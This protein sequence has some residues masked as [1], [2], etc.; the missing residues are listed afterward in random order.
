[1]QAFQNLGYTGEWFVFAGF[2]V[3]MWFRL[4]RREIEFARDAEMGL[5]AEEETVAVRYGEAV[6]SRAVDDAR[7]KETARHFDDGQMVELTVLAAFYGLVSRTLIALDVLTALSAL[8][9]RG[10]GHRAVSAANVV[11]D[12]DGVCVLV[13][14]GLAPRTGPDAPTAMHS[15]PLSLPSRSPSPSSC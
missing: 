6:E 3:F 2:V 10:I 8:H 7:W 14:A 5:V 9:A 11:V 12:A 15:W 13:D 1:M 4:L